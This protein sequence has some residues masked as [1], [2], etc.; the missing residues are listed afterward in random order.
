MKGKD[1]DE[2]E[3]IDHETQAGISEMPDENIGSPRESKL[4]KRTSRKKNREDTKSSISLW[5]EDSGVR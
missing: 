2:E 4:E 1:N 5:V 3:E